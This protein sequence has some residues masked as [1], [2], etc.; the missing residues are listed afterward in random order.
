MRMVQ[1]YNQYRSL[2][3]GEECVVFNVMELMEK[4]GVKARLFMKSSRGIENRLTLK[5]SAFFGGIYNFSACREMTEILREFRPDIVHVNNLYPLFSPSVLVACRR[6]NI[7]I[8]MTIQNYAF[9]CPTAHHL[10]KSVICD[11]CLGGK[12]YYCLIKNCRQN[13]FESLAYC[14]RSAVARKMSFFR[15]NITIYIVPTQ[16]TKLRLIEA[17]FQEKRIILLRNM[18]VTRGEPI[19]SSKGRYVAFAGRMSPEKGVDTLLSAAK[20]LSGIPIH[21][22]GEG[23][24]ID[25]LR[26]N[27]PSNAY[28][29]G[30]LQDEEMS[31]FYRGARF[32]VVPS[33]WY[34][35]CPL[36]I[37][38]AFA[39]GLPVIASRLGGLTEIVEDGVT[40]L[41]FEPRNSDDL[42]SKIKLLWNKPPLCREMGELAYART[43]EELGE[44]VYFDRLMAVY[45]KAIEMNRIG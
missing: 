25:R 7:P 34:E 3:S 21:L 39:H 36:V 9:T 35:M 41:L 37:S 45:K 16:F 38:Q 5:I 2:R 6:L 11:H 27:A 43:I 14:I 8:V 24:M 30:L 13:I 42:A 10:C 28:F 17:G 33:Q 22:A 4:K 44:D 20:K 40:G 32:L 26:K 23:P 12:E 19:D 29:L 1:L 15:D 18:V 31:T